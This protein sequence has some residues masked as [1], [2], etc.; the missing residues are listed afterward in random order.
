M[1]MM[2]EDCLPWSFYNCVSHG[3]VVHKYVRTENER[4]RLVKLGM[5]MKMH[6]NIRDS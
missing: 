4:E 1:F 6:E 5:Q 3:L 2:P